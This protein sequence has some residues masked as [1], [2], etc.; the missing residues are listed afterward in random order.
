MKDDE[1]RKAMVNLVQ[2]TYAK[3]P[4]FLS[5]PELDNS[6][7]FS[8][9]AADRTAVAYMQALYAIC[10]NGTVIGRYGNDVI[11]KWGPGM[12]TRNAVMP[13]PSMGVARKK[14]G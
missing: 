11:G 6:G 10:A 12:S 5:L 2:E 13:T 4:N 3:W 1:S 8:C 9:P 7:D 14:K